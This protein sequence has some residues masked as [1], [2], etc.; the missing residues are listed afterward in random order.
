LC[1]ALTAFFVV[2][3]VLMFI[4]P[5]DWPYPAF[6]DNGLKR[7]VWSV[8]ITRLYSPVMGLWLALLSMPG[9]SYT[10]RLLEWEPLSGFLGSTSYGCFLFHQ[11][12]AQWYWW[13]TRAGATSVVAATSATAMSDELKTHWSWWEYKKE[14]YWFSP[15]PVPVA[16]Y[17]FFFVVMLTTLFSALCNAT[18]LAPL[19]TLWIRFVRLCTRRGGA[20]GVSAHE[21]MAE[22]VMELTGEDQFALEATLGEVGLGSVGLPMLV[23]LLN[24]KEDAL[25]LQVS[26]IASLANLGEVV[27][28]IDAKLKHSQQE[29]G[30]G[31]KAL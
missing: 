13:A 5:L 21:I 27:E 20:G 18:L 4:E 23:G 8:L 12:V 19:T 15:K 10:A 1:D 7:Y 28:L 6:L 24:S 2:F 26:D 22:A 16:W 31:Q 11:I 3:H 29:S 17:E 9:K 30:V 14:Y 25:S